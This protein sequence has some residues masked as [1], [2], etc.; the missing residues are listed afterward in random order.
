VLPPAGRPVWL[1]QVMNVVSSAI[2]SALLP[3]PGIIAASHRLASY[4]SDPR[5]D[6]VDRGERRRAAAAADPDDG[7]L[8][9][10]A[11]LHRLVDGSRPVPPPPLSR[12]EKPRD[13]PT[14]LFL[15]L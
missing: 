15:C 3:I 4:Q 2:T 11:A 9:G 12:P 7:N 14:G 6:K 5:G 13:C 8:L 10:T 1:L